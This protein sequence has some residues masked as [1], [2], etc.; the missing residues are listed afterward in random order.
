M[1]HGGPS[2]RKRNNNID[3]NYIEDEL[4]APIDGG[5]GWVVVMAS[6]LIHI[7]SKYCTYY[8]HVKHNPFFNCAFPSLQSTTHHETA[9]NRVPT[10]VYSI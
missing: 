2:R 7:I 1:A 10:L 6:F 8:L 4:P 5:W 3:Q 9:Q